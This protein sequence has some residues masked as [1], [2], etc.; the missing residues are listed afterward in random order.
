MFFKLT[1]VA[2]PDSVK[3]IEHAC[4]YECDKLTRVIIYA[5]EISIGIHAFPNVTVYAFKD[6]DA[7]KWAEENNLTLKAL[8]DDLFLL[9]KKTTCKL[10]LGKKMQVALNG[11]LEKSFA[12]DN[13]GVA[14]VTKK[15][16][17]TAKKAG[18][19]KITVESTA[20]KKIVLTVKVTDPAKLSKTTLTLK[21]GKSSTLKVSGL[22]GRK[23]TW[24]SS[25]KMI[26]TVED[27]KVTAKK[28]GKCV[29]KARV[30]DGKTLECE[31]TVTKK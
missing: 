11:A 27:G 6:S 22:V 12:S 25:D 10:K 23:V 18:T 1:S 16:V 19:A 24:S 5:K 26:A 15:G 21:A 4:F 17:I 31:V 7:Y 8:P 28:A 2:I 20:G 30:K 3:N 13:T 9:S 29:I 14:T